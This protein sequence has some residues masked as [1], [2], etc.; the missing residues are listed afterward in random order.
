MVEQEVENLEVELLLEAIYR[1]HGYDFRGYARD[2]MSRRL[3]VARLKVGAS[4][5]GE[6]QHRLLV[7]EQL[8][9]VV[10]AQLTVR[11]SDIYRDPEFWLALRQRVVP[12]L[13][14]YPTLKLWLAGCA[15]G[16]EVY[17]MAILL[18]EEGLT[19]RSIIYATDLSSDGLIEAKYGEY[20]E[21]RLATFDANYR[22]AGGK[23]RF[24]D[25]CTVAYDCLAMHSSLRRNV[26]FFEHNLVSDYSPGQMN[27]VFCR[28]VLIYFDAS[29]RQQ[30][31]E[32]F[33]GCLHP[34][35]YLCLGMSEALPPRFRTEFEAIAANERIYRARAS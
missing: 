21:A 17:S 24:E 30:T 5:L 9:R 32:L 34:S 28:N 33:R 2:V 16:E 19:E 18:E 26:V 3:S 14:T 27:V 1:R 23:R 6:L 7:D 15:G 12:T 29:T 22:R 10:L 35:G 31:L 11:V 8:F 20:A 13:R 25:Y 4:S